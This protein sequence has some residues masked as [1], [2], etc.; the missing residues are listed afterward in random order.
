MA[1]VGEYVVKN[2]CEHKVTGKNEVLFRVRWKGY[3]EKDD[4]WE[5][6]SNLRRLDVMKTYLDRHPELQE[7]FKNSR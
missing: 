5:P 6:Y 7:R 3:S 2:I 4:T 1:G